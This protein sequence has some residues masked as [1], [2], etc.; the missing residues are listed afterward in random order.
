[1]C[2]IAPA[3]AAAADGVLQPLAEPQV[4]LQGFFWRRSAGGSGCGQPPLNS[5]YTNLTPSMLATLLSGAAMWS[6]RDVGRINGGGTG[7]G[8]RTL[9]GSGSGG[10]QRRAISGMLDTRANR[11]LMDWEASRRRRQRGSPRVG[12]EVGSWGRR[13]RR[14]RIKVGTSPGATSSARASTSGRAGGWR[15]RHAVRD[16]SPQ[17]LHTT[18]CAVTVVRRCPLLCP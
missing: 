12:E 6:D 15:H 5:S 18:C 4:R 9:S 14:L 7:G 2:S 13:H 3:A 1:M 17:C 11:R 16:T 8:R 10:K